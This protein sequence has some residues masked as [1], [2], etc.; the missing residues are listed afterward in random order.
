MPD[1]P[2]DELVTPTV[3][4]PRFVYFWD[5]DCSSQVSPRG[6][7][8]LSHRCRRAPPGLRW[9]WQA[10]RWAYFITV[11][12]QWRGR[13]HARDFEENVF[14]A[15]HLQLASLREGLENSERSVRGVVESV[16]FYPPWQNGHS[17]PSQF[18]LIDCDLRTLNAQSVHARHRDYSFSRLEYVEFG[19]DGGRA[20]DRREMQHVKFT[21]ATGLFGEGR[22]RLI[23]Q[24]SEGAAPQVR[25]GKGRLPGVP[26][27]AIKA[28][29]QLPLF[30]VS[31]VSLALLLTYAG[32]ASWYDLQ[33]E[34]FVDAVAKN[35]PHPAIQWVVARLS[36]APAPFEF[37]LLLVGLMCLSVAS[38]WFGG[39]C[40]E[41]VKDH[42]STYRDKSHGDRL[43]YQAANWSRPISRY[44]VSGFYVAGLG[45][46][47]WYL[48]PRLGEAVGFYWE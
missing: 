3:D 9:M 6:S 29:G 21:G 42:P 10:L 28:V 36:E 26:W 17:F 18:D 1:V 41:E 30:G 47:L 45:L 13:V 11:P 5:S 2:P 48:L 46:T 16:S 14:H 12:A 37:A 34:R 43:R 25:W 8:W 15:F 20:N 44:I 7:A 22:A 31:N 23:I 33:I 19:E 24:Y 39:R 38:G 35:P 4:N 40:P 32:A 27:K